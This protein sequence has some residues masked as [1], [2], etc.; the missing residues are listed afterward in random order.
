M[1]PNLREKTGTKIAVFLSH[2]HLKVKICLTIIPFT[3]PFLFL[4]E[5]CATPARGIP[6][7]GNRPTHTLTH[8]LQ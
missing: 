2:Q 7:F 3:N 6:L 8:M 1:H 4:S 5:N